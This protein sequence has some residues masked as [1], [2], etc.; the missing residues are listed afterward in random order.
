MALGMLGFAAVGT[1]FAAVVS[2][3]RLQGGLLA[4][5]VFPLT[6][7]LVIAS[8]HMM[9]GSIRTASRLPA[10]RLLCYLRS[11]LYSWS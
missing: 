9:L 2:S 3:S 11:T 5:V 4:L 10:R 1:L 7:P 6:L 8:T